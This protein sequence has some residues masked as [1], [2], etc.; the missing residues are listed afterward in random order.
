MMPV[1]PTY[2]QME[3]TYVLMDPT[4]PNYTT[5]EDIMMM[6]QIRN[7]I[8]DKASYFMSTAEQELLRAKMND[9]INKA[10]DGVISSMDAFDALSKIDTEVNLAATK[11]AGVTVFGLT[12]GAAL[13]SL[14]GLGLVGWGIY[15]L[16]TD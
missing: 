10:E 16:V 8:M 15:A 4:P 9:V 6:L 11:K 13:V 14:I 12:A 7:Q 1:E 3:P 5:S 2:A